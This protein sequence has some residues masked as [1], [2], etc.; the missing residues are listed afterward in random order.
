MANALAYYATGFIMVVK[1]FIGQ[2]INEPL[3]V[4]ITTVSI[5]TLSIMINKTRLS[6]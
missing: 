6:V 2:A 4:S 5:M 3:T 1:S